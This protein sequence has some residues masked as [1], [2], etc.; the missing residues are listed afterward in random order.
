MKLAGYPAKS[1]HLLR[2]ILIAGLPEAFGI[3]RRSDVELA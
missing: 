1:R 3:K 2:A